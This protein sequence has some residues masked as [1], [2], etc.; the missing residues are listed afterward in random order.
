MTK[1][2]PIKLRTGYQKKLADAC[3]VGTATVKRALEWQAD[4]DI[5]NLIRK[6]AYDL[7]Y[8]RRF[9]STPKKTAAKDNN[10]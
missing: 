9:P 4:T 1:R 6:K 10:N 2:K 7:G 5:Q 8:V 3:G